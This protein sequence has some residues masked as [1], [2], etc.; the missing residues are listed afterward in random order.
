VKELYIKENLSAAHWKEKLKALFIMHLKGNLETSFLASIL[1][2]LCNDQ[3]TGIL[4]LNNNDEEVRIF[5]QDG[6]IIYATGSRRET[7][8]GHILRNEGH[9]T[10][11]QLLEGLDLSEKSGQALGKILVNKGWISR[12]ILKRVICKQAEEFIFNAFLW[13]KGTFE[14]KDAELNLKKMVIT[15]LNAMNIILE[16]SRRID[17]MSI[18]AERISSD[19]LTFKISEGIADKK[20]VKI[21][22]N[23]W[24]ILSLIDGRRTV[25]QLID[26]S[27]FDDFTAYK[28]LYS[29]V[30]SG[31]IQEI[32]GGI[33]SADKNNPDLFYATIKIYDDIL[34]ILIKDLETELGKWPFTIIDP[35]ASEVDVPEKE[36]IGRFRDCEFRKWIFSIIAEC[37]SAL[38][39][40]SQTLLED[41]QPNNPLTENNRDILSFM[42]SFKNFDEGRVHIKNGFNEFVENVFRKTADILGVHPTRKMMEKIEKVLHHLRTDR[43]DSYKNSDILE[44][45]EQIIEKI[46]MQIIMDKK[47]SDAESGIFAIS[48]ET[49]HPIE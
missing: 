26:E 22:A 34:K 48:P 11:Q 12:E 7:R 33:Q 2:L 9:L 40:P 20:E 1:Q 25:R 32:I 13:Q 8:M 29:F 35:N 43:K 49:N 41:Y 4:Q 30:S 27:G 21:N 10:S 31:F 3:K 16:A 14:Y 17:E 44:A 24:R 42:K 46:E 47:R 19:Q 5:L 28:V 18:L 36:A 45:V 37:K 39:P 23:E 15:P 6:K 38:S